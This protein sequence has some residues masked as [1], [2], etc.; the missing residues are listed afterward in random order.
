MPGSH[1]RLSSVVAALF[2]CALPSLARPVAQDV[3]SRL[4]YE[5]LDANHDGVISFDEY[6][7]A[8]RAQR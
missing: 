3:V 5:R 6:R 8:Q 7:R 1:R 4:A 2:V